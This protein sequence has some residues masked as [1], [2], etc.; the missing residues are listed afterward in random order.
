ME[1]AHAREL[2]KAKQVAHYALKT[3]SQSSRDVKHLGLKSMIS[4]QILRKYSRNRVLKKVR[5]VKLTVPSQG[6][7]VLRELRTLIIP[8]LGAR[9]R[10]R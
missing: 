7:K 4:N 2:R 8:C 1:T 5:S 3:R 6:I 9:A 10:A